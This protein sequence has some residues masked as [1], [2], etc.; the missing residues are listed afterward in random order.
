MNKKIISL[1]AL[2][3]SVAFVFTSCQKDKNDKL[4][5]NVEQFNADNNYYKGESDQIDNDINSALNDIPAFGGRKEEAYSSPMCGCTIDSSQIDSLILIFNFD[6]VTP[7]FSPSR[8]RS[9]QIKVELTSGAQWGDAGSVLKLTYIDFKV[10]RMSDNASI[11][12]NGVKT[13]KN[14][15]GNNWIALYLGTGTFKYQE[16][17]F[18]IH[19]EFSGGDTA[20]WNSARMTEWSYS[21][22]Q[23]NITFTSK[24]DTTVNGF[25][26]TDSWGTDRWGGDFTVYYNT[27]ILSDTYC[28]LWR[29]KSGELVDHLSMGDFTL[30]LGVDQNG[31]ASTLQ[32]AYGYKITWTG[33]SG[34]VSSAILSY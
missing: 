32:C 23:N 16:R 1:F 29:A 10:T 19:V 33:S 24:G 18:N 17:A 13:L 11:T 27:P 21:A 2:A 4:D 26:N 22:G 12:F 34:N 5:G 20:I 9:G 3:L 31:N 7:C 6:G 8:T 25:A 15:N 30:T 28:G 14:I